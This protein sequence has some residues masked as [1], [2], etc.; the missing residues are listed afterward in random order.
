MNAA[1]EVVVKCFLDLW[2]THGKSE[3]ITDTETYN[4][5]PSSVSFQFLHKAWRMKSSP[6]Q[7][8][9]MGVRERIYNNH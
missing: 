1:Y 9:F 4:L 5:E 7:I 2:K 3:E 8:T 6:S